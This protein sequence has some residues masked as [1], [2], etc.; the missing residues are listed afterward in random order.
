MYL[1]IYIYLFSLSVFIYIYLFIW[2]TFP[3]HVAHGSSR[4]WTS[5]GCMPGQMGRFVMKHNLKGTLC[6]NPDEEILRIMSWC[7]FTLS[8]QRN[9]PVSEECI[10]IIPSLICFCQNPRGANMF[11]KSWPNHFK[12]QRIIASCSQSEDVFDF[13]PIN[14]QNS[15]A[16]CWEISREMCRTAATV[17]NP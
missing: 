8:P 14:D 17:K 1:Y 5:V 4:E 7:L 16:K 12:S 13:F 15:A 11:M 10:V 6:P 9:A 3:T 2:D